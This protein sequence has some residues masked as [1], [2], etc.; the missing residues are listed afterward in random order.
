MTGKQKYISNELFHFIGKG[1][2]THEQYDILKK[3]LSNCSIGLGNPDFSVH[4]YNPG[5]KLSSNELYDPDMVCFCDIPIND[6]SLHMVKYSGFGL[7]FKKNYLI[8]KGA[9]PVWYISS[10]S[11]T[12][13]KPIDQFRKNFEYHDQKH[14]D[15]QRLEKL[16]HKYKAFEKNNLKDEIL[17]YFSHIYSFMKFFNAEKADDD[18]EN[19][20]M[21]RE[22]RICGVLNFKSID[23]VYRVILPNNFIKQFKR[24]FPNY[25][26]Q[27]SFSDDL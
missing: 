6:I 25:N 7:S 5:G 4:R 24:D 17:C 10:N 9:N 12:G 15:F 8:T 26:A 3:I 18:H 2:E 23:N 20:Y 16:M 13:P 27:I 22:W 1:K 21:E 14:D 19:Y 11:Q